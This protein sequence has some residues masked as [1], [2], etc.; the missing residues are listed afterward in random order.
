MPQHQVV[1]AKNR[2]FR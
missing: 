1:M 2:P